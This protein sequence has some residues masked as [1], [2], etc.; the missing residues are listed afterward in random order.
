MYPYKKIKTSTTIKNSIYSPRHID[1][2]SPLSYQQQLPSLS[3]KC[4]IMNENTH[5]GR[6]SP[7][8]ESTALQSPSD[9]DLRVPCYCEE[10]AWRVAYRHLNTDNTTNN[11]TSSGD[12][13]DWKYFIVFISN[14]RKCCPMFMQ[15]AISK[16]D[17]T[18]FVCWD[19]HVIVMR[20]T[21]QTNINNEDEKIVSEVLDIDTWITPYPTPLSQY[22]DD[23]FPHAADP[24]FNKQFL[25]LFYVVRAENFIRD[26][27]SD[28]MHMFKNGNWISPPPEYPPIM[29]GLKIDE[30]RDGLTGSNLD[31]YISMSGGAKCVFTLAEMY[32]RSKGLDG[33]EWTLGSTYVI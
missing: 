17:T 25:P 14:N 16:D 1:I 22:L 3:I 13:I 8:A 5:N 2:L 26:F 11:N 20:S 28:R 30:D 19:Y 33:K 6:P 7:S 31:A 9:H 12:N 23:S 10:N 21:V 18:D 4:K 24:N 27:Y 29:N 32:E 15:R